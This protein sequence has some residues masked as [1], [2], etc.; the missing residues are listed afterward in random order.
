MKYLLLVFLLF[1]VIFY[2]QSQTKTLATTPAELLKKSDNQYAAGW[3]LLGTGT[4]SLIS[5]IAIT[6]N[7]DYYGGS[8]NASLINTLAWIGSISVVVSVPFF[9][10]SGNNARMAARLALQNQALHQPIFAPGQGRTIPAIS[11]KIPL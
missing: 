11:L 5:A 9:L 10:S 2:T 8:N 1:G 6:P 3:I 4:V 7:Y